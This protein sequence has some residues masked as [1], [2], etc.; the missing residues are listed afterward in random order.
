M[1]INFE[2]IRDNLNPRSIYWTTVCFL[3]NN[4]KWLLFVLFLAL[5]GYGAFLWYSFVI[6]P[7]WSDVRRQEYMKT[8]DK[9]AVLNV[10]RLNDVIAERDA[11]MESYQKNREGLEDIF[12]LKK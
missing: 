9:G 12:R 10:N 3:E 4:V 11:R 8:K 6:N 5:A 1:K 2:K 7:R